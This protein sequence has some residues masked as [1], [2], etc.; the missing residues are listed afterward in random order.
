M[1]YA[2]ATLP[3]VLGFGLTLLD[4]SARLGTILFTIV[5]AL[6]DWKYLH[7]GFAPYPKFT[8]FRIALDVLI[9]VVLNRRAVRLA[10]QLSPVSL[11]L[12]D[13]SFSL[14]AAGSA[15]HTLRTRSL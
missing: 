10:F 13:D 12:H 3:A 15:L 7:S 9:I 5:H 11:L 14:P 1:C 2:I 8:V 4:E 6:F